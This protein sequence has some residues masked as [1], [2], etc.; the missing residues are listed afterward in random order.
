MLGGLISCS[1]SLPVWIKWSSNLSVRKWYTLWHFEQIG[2]RFSA[3]SLPLKRFCMQ[4]CFS[5]EFGLPQ[6]IHFPCAISLLRWGIGL[7]VFFLFLDIFP[8][9]G[10]AVFQNPKFNTRTHLN[11]CASNKGNPHWITFCLY[12]VVVG[13][14]VNLVEPIIKF[15]T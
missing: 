13:T 3:E 15:V 1:W 7:L 12:I 4:W 6:K 10:I 9:F 2:Y 8:P 5:N 14:F 11:T